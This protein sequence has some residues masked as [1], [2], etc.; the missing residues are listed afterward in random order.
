MSAASPQVALVYQ[1]FPIGPKVLDWLNLTPEKDLQDWTL[2]AFR[3]FQK[4][5]MTVA[6]PNSSLTLAEVCHE[7]LLMSMPR[8]VLACFDLWRFHHRRREPPLPTGLVAEGVAA[9]IL[10]DPRRAADCFVLLQSKWPQ[11]PASYHNMARVLAASPEA[12]KNWIEVGLTHCPNNQALWQL[13]WQSLANEADAVRTVEKLAGQVSSWRGIS[14]AAH[15]RGDL[16]EATIAKLIDRYDSFYRSGETDPDFLVEYTGILGHAGFFSQ[17]TTIVWHLQQLKD[18]KIPWEVWGHYLQS[19]EALG[20]TS[21]ATDQLET[22]RPHIPP[23][24]TN[25]FESILG[26]QP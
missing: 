9:L 19:L 22:L 17:V 16:D 2:E 11:E 6:P 4:D 21:L 15:L 20:R 25:Y 1:K 10:G 8:A 14:L 24:H 13:Y 5:L 26:E 7:L 18:Q 3:N 12:M 23:E